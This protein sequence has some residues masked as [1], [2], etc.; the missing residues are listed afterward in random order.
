MAK[1]RKNESRIG[2]TGKVYIQNINRAIKNVILVGE[3][4]DTRNS[5]TAKKSRI[6]RL[7]NNRCSIPG[8]RYRMR[9]KKRGNRQHL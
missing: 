1:K 8:R 6:A 7:Q 5:S 4:K 3:I 9:W 2:L